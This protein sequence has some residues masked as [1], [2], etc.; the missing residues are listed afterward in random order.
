MVRSV[1]LKY[2][3]VTIAGTVNVT[4]L[5][6]L[7]SLHVLNLST[8]IGKRNKVWKFAPTLQGALIEIFQN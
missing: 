3:D 5:W 7:L 4:S 2:S 8:L 1:G 6:G